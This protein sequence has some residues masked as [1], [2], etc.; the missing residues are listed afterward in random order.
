[1]NRSVYFLMIGWAISCV[2]LVSGCGLLRTAR[3]RK[4]VTL[5]TYRNIGSIIQPDSLISIIPVL[6]KEASLSGI[7]FSVHEAAAEIMSVSL[8]NTGFRTLDKIFTQEILN[9]HHM[10]LTNFSVNQAVS[11]GKA[12]GADYLVLVSLTELEEVTR[13]INFGP[14]QIITTVDTSVLVGLNCRLVDVA[15][16]QVIWTGVATTQDKNL[17]LALRRISLQLIHSFQNGQK[18][19]PKDRT[20]P[21]LGIHY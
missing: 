3:I 6:H 19:P 8:W 13:S 15:K 17:Q 18:K 9:R 20:I 1:M 2:I 7:S 21:L 10:Q 11:V 5:N 4:D 14:F 12:L 16:E